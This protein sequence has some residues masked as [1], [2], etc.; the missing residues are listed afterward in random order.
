M[1]II[2]LDAEKLAKL[3]GKDEATVKKEFFKENE[4]GEIVAKE[5]ALEVLETHIQSEISRVDDEAQ[6]KGS[7]ERMSDFENKL[8]KEFGFEGNTQGEALIKKIV[9]AQVKKAREE[10]LKEVGKKEPTAEE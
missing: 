6:K 7:R 1:S 4:E 3:T 9:D 2:Q 5:D 10:A 8:R